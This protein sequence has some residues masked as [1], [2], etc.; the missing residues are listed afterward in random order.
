MAKRR[1]SAMVDAFP[2]ELAAVASDGVVHQQEEQRRFLLAAAGEA[3]DILTTPPANG[4]K[5]KK[6]TTTTTTTKTMFSVSPSMHSGAESSG[7]DNPA[8]RNV[9]AQEPSKIEKDSTSETANSGDFRDDNQYHDAQNAAQR[10]NGAA[11]SIH[12]KR[13]AT[14]AVN[15][16][17]AVTES[18]K[19][20]DAKPTLSLKKTPSK[21]RKT[22]D[23]ERTEDSSVGE[24]KTLDTSPSTKKPRRTSHKTPRRPKESQKAQKMA[25]EST[26]KIKM[27][28]PNQLSYIVRCKIRRVQDFAGTTSR[29]SLTRSSDNEK[30]IHIPE[31]NL[32]GTLMRL[33]VD[34]ELG[35]AETASLDQVEEAIIERFTAPL[36]QQQ[37]ET[38]YNWVKFDTNVTTALEKE[39]Q[40]KVAGYGLE[41]VN[42]IEMEM[43][44]MN[45]ELLERMKWVDNQGLSSSVLFTAARAAGG[46]RQQAKTQGVFSPEEMKKFYEETWQ[47][48][49]ND[50]AQAELGK[51]IREGDSTEQ[52]KASRKGVCP[53]PPADS[54]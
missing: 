17:T 30:I 9:D 53:A 38:R 45:C 29:T 32:L 14:K 54:V 8:P 52:E 3:F 41:R 27:P 1:A 7:P 46:E 47:K 33:Y 37:R 12:N 43:E 19:L 15:S 50:F 35:A 10:P 44:M 26:A 39:I 25:V 13:K 40:A 20:S 42:L 6:T 21:K 22:H 2:G 11:K 34:Y 24:G 49:Q 31:R 18:P 51:T 23:I 36:G 48:V 4:K 5:K 28:P 16:S